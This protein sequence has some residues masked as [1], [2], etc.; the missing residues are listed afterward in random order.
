MTRH[1]IK[2]LHDKQEFYLEWST[3]T[4]SPVTNGMSL[5]EFKE[6]YRK[7]Y[8]K[9]GLNKLAKKLER[10]EKKRCSA[11]Y[12]SLETLLSINHAGDNNKELSVEEIIEKYC[13]NRVKTERI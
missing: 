2:L 6:Y 10:V 7:E 4:D 1:I 13:L 12:E 8:G 5:E 11:V 9:K 3:I